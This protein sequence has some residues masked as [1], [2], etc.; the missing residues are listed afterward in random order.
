M[1]VDKMNKYNENNDE[2]II[3]EAEK[4]IFR[5]YPMNLRN[6]TNYIIYNNKNN[7]K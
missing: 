3:Q 1:L 6:F 4:V 7:R 2:Y 5:G